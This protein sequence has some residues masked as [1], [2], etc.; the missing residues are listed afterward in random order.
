MAPEPL[1][2]AFQGISYLQRQTFGTAENETTGETTGK[3]KEKSIDTAQDPKI[4]EAPSGKIE[5]FIRDS[6]KSEPVGDILKDK[7]MDS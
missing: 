7:H 1:T 5:E 6:N 4:D 3:S 2:K